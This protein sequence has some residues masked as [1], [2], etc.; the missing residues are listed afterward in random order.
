L[1]GRHLLRPARC[2]NVGRF[3]IFALHSEL[4]SGL[5]ACTLKLKIGKKISREVKRKEGGNA[6]ERSSILAFANAF[7]KAKLQP[8]L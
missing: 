8:N 1:Q 6:F 7:K 4:V 3:G 5:K 2:T